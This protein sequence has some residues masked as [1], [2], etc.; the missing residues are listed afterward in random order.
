MLT[1]LDLR[2]Y[3]GDLAEAIPR[4]AG[5]EPDVVD[6]VREIITAVR[7]RGD[8]ALRELTQRFDGCVLVDDL[9]VPELEIE[10][11]LDRIDP[12]LRAAL[13]FAGDQ[14]L[15]YHES[16]RESDGKHERHGVHVRDVVVPVERAG[17][18]VPGGR[19]AYPST[20]LMTAIPARIAGVPEVVLCVPPDGDTGLPPDATLA[21][22]ALADVDEVY[23]IGG[24]QAIAAM[25]YGT[26]SVAAVDVI[27]GPGNRYVTTAKREVQG[28]VGID[29]L[30]AESELAVIGDGSTNPEWVAADLL[31][32]AE[33]GPGGVAVVITWNEAFADAVDAALVRRLE[34]TTRRAEAAATLF[35]GGRMILVD[36]ATDAIAVANVI[37]PEHL[38]LMNA[39]PEMLVPEVRNAGAVF[40]GPYAPAVIGD[41]VAG[42]N[43]V[44]PTNGTAR[45][46][47]ALRVSSFQKHIHVVSLDRAALDRVGPYVTT[48]AASE[49]LDAHAQTIE[50]RRREDPS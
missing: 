50:V 25:A 10:R 18:Y 44:L 48:L 17:L 11:A 37:A 33:H 30:A 12:D 7:E 6:A 4:P 15:A 24:A 38:Q 28:V 27:V 19:A 42:T 9:R 21:A 3:E 13:E 23:R 8:E 29:S 43:H 31:A 5:A 14:I 2:G 20:V 47:S 22:A 40:C 16:Q 49:G 45:F 41:Y 39:D 36:E 32:Q 34:R 46:A 26:E 1:R 35:S